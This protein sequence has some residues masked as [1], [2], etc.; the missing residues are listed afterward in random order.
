M[1]YGVVWVVWFLKEFLKF[2]VED[3][4]DIGLIEGMIVVI[5]KEILY[6]VFDVICVCF[7]FDLEIVEFVFDD[8]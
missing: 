3:I 7:K 4:I 6:F 8:C 1:E 5:M 2:L